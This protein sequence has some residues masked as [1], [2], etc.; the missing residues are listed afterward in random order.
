MVTLLKEY[1]TKKKLK[2]QNTEVNRKTV[3]KSK[4]ILSEKEKVKKN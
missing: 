2:E 1:E 4:F 3:E